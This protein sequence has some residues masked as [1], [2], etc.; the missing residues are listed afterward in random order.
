MKKNEFIQL[1]DAL[2]RRAKAEKNQDVCIAY[3]EVAF[4]IRQILNRV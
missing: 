1:A 3:E 4:E 2:D